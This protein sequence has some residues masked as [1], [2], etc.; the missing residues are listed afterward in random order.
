MGL[1]EVFQKS[2]L[3][4]FHKVINNVSQGLFD[5]GTPGIVEY[6]EFNRFTL[7]LEGIW[8]FHDPHNMEYCIRGLQ[9]SRRASES[10]MKNSLH[11]LD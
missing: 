6:S 7:C 5:H 10:F 8:E 2:P 1:Y 9:E 3:H 11:F 4:Q